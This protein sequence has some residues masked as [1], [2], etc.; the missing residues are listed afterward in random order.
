MPLMDGIEATQL[1]HK[2]SPS[3]RII[4]L[5][6]RESIVARLNFIKAG[7]VT[8]MSKDN[9]EEDFGLWIKRD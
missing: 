5:S 1:I 7:A 4:G 9:I 6:N 8:C 3:T 2:A